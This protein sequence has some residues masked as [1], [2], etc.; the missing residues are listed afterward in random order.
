[1]VILDGATPKHMH[2]VIKSILAASTLGFAAALP[3]A[4]AQ[5]L[6]GGTSRGEFVDPALPFT[7]VINS[8]DV[9]LFQS[10]IPSQ[11]A[12]TQT[13]IEFT[14]AA[15]GAVD[16][17]GQLDLGNIVINNGRTLGG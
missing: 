17:G 14:A 8:T 5:L 12:H 2:T 15:F 11:A 16:N 1:R 9:S 6:S 10:G 13:S 3:T 7:S 4:H